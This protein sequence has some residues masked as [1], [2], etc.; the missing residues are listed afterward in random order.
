MSRKYRSRV[1]ILLSILEAIHRKEYATIT[2]IIIRANIPHDRLK[3]ILDRL[4]E[5]GYVQCVEKGDRRFYTL[6]S[7]GYILMN[8]LRKIRDLMMGLGLGI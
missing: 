8:E 1:G 5:K 6:T 4:I 3:N 7:K 2:E